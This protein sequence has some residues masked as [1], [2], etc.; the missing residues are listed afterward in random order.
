MAATPSAEPLIHPRLLRIFERTMPWL[1]R[2]H[3]HRAVGLEHFPRTGPVLVALH[4]TFATY[5]GILLARAIH[6]ATGRIG[7]GLG[8]DLIFKVP[9]LRRFGWNASIRPAKRGPAKVRKAW[10]R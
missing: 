10:S 5:D 8:D 4:H 6:E 3:R 1:E 7:V 9:G 2:L